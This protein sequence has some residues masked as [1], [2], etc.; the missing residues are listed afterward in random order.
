M[1]ISYFCLALECSNIRITNALH[2]S[3]KQIEEYQKW[4]HK[5]QQNGNMLHRVPL[6]I[7]DCEICIIA[8]QQFGLAL[9]D[10]PA[11]FIDDVRATLT[12]K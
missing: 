6:N 12:G 1:N 4:L 11:E 10:V 5:V 7:I 8:V 9:M 2:V 3:F